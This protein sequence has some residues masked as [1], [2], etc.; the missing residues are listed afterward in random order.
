MQA[1]VQAAAQAGQLNQF[2]ET[3]RQQNLP[4][5]QKTYQEPPE[6][7]YLNPMNVEC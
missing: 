6:H 1:Q 3:L 5:G 2:H 4:P 7:H